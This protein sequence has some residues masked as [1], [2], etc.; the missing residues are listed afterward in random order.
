[1]LS[2]LAPSGV[3][4]EGACCGSVIAALGSTPLLAGI[5]GDETKKTPPL[6]I[7]AA[8]ATVA[9]PPTES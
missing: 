7:I 3:P 9:E 1:M 6:I 2:T 4:I 5:L 8:R